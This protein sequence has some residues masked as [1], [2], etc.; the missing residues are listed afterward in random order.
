MISRSLSK[1]GKRALSTLKKKT[2]TRGDFD[3]IEQVEG[4]DFFRQVWKFGVD[5]FAE[6]RARLRLHSGP[7]RE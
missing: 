7:E 4:S 5:R 1:R 6:G 3:D 2:G